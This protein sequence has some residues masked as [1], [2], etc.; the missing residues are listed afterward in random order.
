MFAPNAAMFMA[1]LFAALGAAAFVASLATGV[2]LDRRL[3]HEVTRE[4]LGLDLVWPLGVNVLLFTLFACHHSLLARTGAKAW[5]TRAAPPGLERSIYVWTASLLFGAACLI[6]R[7]APAL[8]YDVS[9][10]AGW[11][12]TG[13][14]VLGVWLTI[15][16]A[17]RIA[18]RR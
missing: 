13:L 1:R 6:W 14:R 2:L 11:G 16:A 9:G 18:P 15:E 5:V 17:A 7:P 10:A 3:A 4:P 12:L 8:V